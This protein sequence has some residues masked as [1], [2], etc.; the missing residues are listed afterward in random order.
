M[1]PRPSTSALKRADFNS[2]PVE[3][4]ASIF[5][6]IPLQDKLNLAQVNRFTSH[7]A[8][9]A[10]VFSHEQYDLRRFGVFEVPYILERE[11]GHV[12]LGNRRFDPV[13]A[14]LSA[15]LERPYPLLSLDFNLNW[16]WAAGNVAHQAEFEA[17]LHSIGRIQTLSHLRIQ[18]RDS[19]YLPQPVLDLKMLSALPNLTRLSLHNSHFSVNCESIALLS[20][21]TML[22]ISQNLGVDIPDTFTSLRNLK[23]LSIYGNILK[24]VPPVVLAMSSLTMLNIGLN[25]LHSLPPE[26]SHQKLPHL[27]ELVLSAN[28]DLETLPDELFT[29]TGLRSLDLRGLPLTELPDGLSQLTNLTKLRL[30]MSSVEILPDFIATLWRLQHFDMAS[31]MIPALPAGM[32]QLTELD[33]LNISEGNMLEVPGF[34]GSSFRNLVV[35]DMRDVTDHPRSLPCTLGELTRLTRLNLGCNKIKCVPEWV[36][37]LVQLRCLDLRD[38]QLTR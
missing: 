8:R 26:F 25:C 7:V 1:N 23:S 9:T 32:S 38:N 2:L 4:V 13:N 24:H 17:L 33:Y 16:D 10:R 30:G 19:S 20:A 29:L 12:S 36:G 28:M 15:H 5:L 18:K 34:V 37:E 14:F 27:Q 31:T 21:L 6:L 3:L 11:F 22:D 35:L